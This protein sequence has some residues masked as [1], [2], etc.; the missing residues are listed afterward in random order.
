MFLIAFS[1][2]AIMRF[3][4]VTLAITIVN[5]ISTYLGS[6]HIF[7]YANNL[8]LAKRTSSRVLYNTG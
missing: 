6:M 7:L 5:K 1:L 4:S 2:G 3:I 8:I